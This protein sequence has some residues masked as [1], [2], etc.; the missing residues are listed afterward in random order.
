MPARI[1][2][3]HNDGTFLDALVTALRTDAYG[4]AGFD[5]SMNAWEA[6]R[7]ASMRDILVTR[8]QFGAGQPHG[9]ALARWAR[10]IAPGV[11]VLFVAR[12][13]FEGDAE[14]LGVFVPRPVEVLK[15]VEI[16][17]RLAVGD[18]VHWPV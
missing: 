3:V 7:S 15:V 9:I 11:R 4:V 10:S 13:E 16:V 5:N 2:V 6:L 12:P 8:I 1:I 14:G 17:A 18:P